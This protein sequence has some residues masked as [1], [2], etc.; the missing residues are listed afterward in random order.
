[1]DFIKFGYDKEQKRAICLNKISQLIQ[2][3]EKYVPV[4][5][6]YS[7][8]LEL[9]CT[10]SNMFRGYLHPSPVF[11]L[12]VGNTKRGR[13]CK[14]NVSVEKISH[15]YWLNDKYQL[16]YIETMNACNVIYCESLIYEQNARIGITT[17]GEGN[18]TGISEEKY[19]RN[20]ITSFAYLSY[21]KTANGNVLCHLHWEE[22][23]YDENG[24]CFCEFVSNYNP[25]YEPFTFSQ[26][27]FTVQN[28]LI[29]SY[30][31]QKSTQYSV[32]HKKRDATGEIYFI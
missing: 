12:I 17:D 23:K 22:Y 26:Y 20:R 32:A 1:M 11:D 30:T 5:M 14:G 2:Y 21:C 18:I 9:S 27:L 10:G 6:D 19:E 4:N 3:V 13:K 16:T 29:I 7:G 28:G 24:L 15:R 25:D 31:N 8:L